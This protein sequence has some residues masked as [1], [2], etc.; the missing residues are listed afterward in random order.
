MYVIT[1]LGN[2]GTQYAYTRHN[3]GF[4]AMDFLAD[5]WGIKLK[6]IRHKAVLGEGSVAGEKVVLAKPQTFMNNSGE[7]VRELLSYYKVPSDRLVVIYDDVSL[8]PGRLRIRTK[9][10]AGGHNGIKS[11]LYQIQTDV[12][13]RIKLGVGEKPPH[14]DLADWV[15]GRFTDEDIAAIGP[16]VE[17]LPDLL[18]L[19]MREGPAA[20]MNR[21]NN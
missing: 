18:T 21:Y 17:E 19:L 3:V 15:L 1:G 9:G 2:P 4:I 11:I 6:K 10:S 20:A 14:Y 7:S 5:R 16:R 8:A 13:P 12:F